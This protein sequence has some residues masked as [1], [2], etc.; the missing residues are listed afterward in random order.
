M[1]KVIVIAPHPDDETLGCG[2]TLCKH[3]AE[4]DEIYWLLVT[5]IDEEH[6]WPVDSVE[7]RQKEIE[8]VS[9]LYG[10]TKMFKL[11]FPATRLDTIPVVDLIAGI[12][13]VFREVEP[14]II[15]LPNRS[16]IHTDHQV[17]FKA[18]MSCCKDFR[19]PFIKRILM[20]EV[21][22]ETEFAP[23]LGENAFLPD[24]L[25]DV[26]KYF[27]RKVEIFRAY[28]SELMESPLPR[29]AETVTGLARYRGS[30][31]GCEYGEAFSLLFE[32]VT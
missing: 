6:G 25:V 27:H 24:V 26:S 4:G 29:S 18:A 32:K 21:L 3:K 11:D 8:T 20:Y 15:Y 5:N 12:N 23:A 30:R 31:I 2:A 9:R 10:F 17:V 13:A 22:S 14:N 19:S 28:S 16:D 1:N 7:A